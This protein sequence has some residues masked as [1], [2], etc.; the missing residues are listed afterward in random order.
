MV[1]FMVLEKVILSSCLHTFVN[2]HPST[3]DYIVADP[4]FLPGVKSFH[5]L[6]NEGLSYHNCSCCSK[7]VD[8]TV[9]SY[10]VQ[11]IATVEPEQKYTLLPLK[12]V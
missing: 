8:T 9:Y 4:F 6:P 7:L 1:R 5:A 3:I 11:N 10:Q 12:N 2:T